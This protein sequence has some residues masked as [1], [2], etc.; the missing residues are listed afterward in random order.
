MELYDLEEDPNE[1][2][3]LAG[4]EEVGGLEHTLT[5]KLAAWMHETNDPL[6]RGPVPSPPLPAHGGP[7]E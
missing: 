1:G 5:E 3:N 7:F 6:L 4:R 2:N